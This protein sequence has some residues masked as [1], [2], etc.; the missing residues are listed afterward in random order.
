MAHKTLISVLVTVLLLAGCSATG[1]KVAVPT[2]TEGSGRLRVAASFYPLYEF[3]AAVGG[4]KVEVVVLVPNGT[5]PHD[6]EPSPGHIRTLNAA[7]VFLYNGADLEH[8]VKKVLRSVENKSLVSVETSK[9]FNLIAGDPHIWLDPTGVAHQVGQIRDAMAKADPANKPFYEANAAAYL[10]KLQALDGEFKQGLA[11]CKRKEFFTS[12][13]AFGYLARRYGLKQHS[14]S[15]L[16]P[17]SEPKPRDLAKVVAEARANKIQVIF[18]ETLVSDKVANV[19][20]KEI[21]AKTLV[22]NPFEGLTEAEVKAGKDYLAIMRAN[23]AGL[24]E[25]LECGQ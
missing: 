16:S 1:S 12:H 15:G 14:I 21:G 5:E 19:V 22:L 6:W 24:K 23:L 11:G 10:S 3:A 8:W 13:D 2:F 18:F 7:S 9:G 25:A 4:E 20:A 17:E